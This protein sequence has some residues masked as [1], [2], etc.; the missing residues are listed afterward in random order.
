MDDL[1]DTRRITL[2][3]HKGKMIPT[4]LLL[5][6]QGGDEQAHKLRTSTKKQERY[7]CPLCDQE[8]II[9]AR[10]SYKIHHF[11][12]KNNSADCPLKENR[13]KNGG[14]G[15]NPE[16]ELT[17]KMLTYILEILVAQYGDEG[18]EFKKYISGTDKSWRRPD[19]FLPSLKLGIEFQRTWLN[20]DALV[21]RNK[22]AE[23][24]GYALLWLNYS[25][26]DSTTKRD[27]Q[28]ANG[29]K[30]AHCFNEDTYKL[31]LDAKQFLMFSEC[32]N[33]EVNDEGIDHSPIRIHSII[34]DLNLSKTGECSL[35]NL[36]DGLKNEE[37]ALAI[38]ACRDKEAHEARKKLENEIMAQE[39][40]EME[41]LI[42][43]KELREKIYKK[44]QN[45]YTELQKKINKN[46]EYSDAHE[47]NC[48]FL[49]KVW[50]EKIKKEIG[51][52]EG[53]FDKLIKLNSFWLRKDEFSFLLEGYDKSYPYK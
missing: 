52:K 14:E 11:Q 15:G 4:R 16:A 27:M 5:P 31:S 51:L 26:K 34:E 47:K 49:E 41:F 19:F 21:G 48:L 45:A 6:L 30:V 13:N 12:H 25:L 28:F 20:V 53:E 35:K 43:K 2:V 10:T 50:N 1:V 38:I 33:F 32:D 9:Y 40:K 18:V 42:K 39:K 37:Q 29:H 44:S 22:F 3:N 8:L 23:K 36:P 7:K 46:D 24:Q 17:A